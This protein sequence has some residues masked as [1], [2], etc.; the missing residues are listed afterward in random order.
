[1]SPVTRNSE[2]ETR[3]LSGDQ[4]IKQNNQEKQKKQDGGNK[5][6]AEAGIVS[7]LV[8]NNAGD[9]AHFPGAM[10]HIALNVACQR[11][12]PMN[13][14]AHSAERSLTHAGPGCL[15][16]RLITS[17]RCISEKFFFCWGRD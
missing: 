2:L 13:F 5:H 8:Q 7:R 11:G 16:I 9:L 6:K 3:N 17:R 12:S 4:P 15:S 14:R 1:L 10:D